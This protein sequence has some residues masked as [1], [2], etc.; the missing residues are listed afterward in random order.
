MYY[1]LAAA[2]ANKKEF[3]TALSNIESA[4]TI[5]PRYPD[6]LALRAQIGRMVQP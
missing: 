3:P 6:A 5:N 1:G 4:L 2:Y